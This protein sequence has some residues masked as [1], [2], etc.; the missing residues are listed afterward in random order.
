MK[1]EL[2][3][4][5]DLVQRL[6]S[7]KINYMLTGSLA[8]MHYG[9]PRMTRDLDVVIEI[10]DVD[11]VDKMVAAFS[12][13]YYIDR[14]MIKQSLKTQTMFNIVHNE[15]VIKVDFIV[16]KRDRYRELEFSRRKRIEIDGIKVDVVSKEDL[17]LS[18]LVWIK[19]MRSELQVNDV[20]NLCKSNYDSNY[21]EHWADRLSIKQLFDEV[22]RA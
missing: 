7:I 14:E 16:K 4:L 3:V 13:Y 5:K 6:E 10:N 21:I 2:A 11:D 19:D 9:V 12:G 1:D 15:S 20:K 22:V 17:I 8:M 18:K